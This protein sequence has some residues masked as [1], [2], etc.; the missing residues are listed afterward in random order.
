MTYNMD[1][2]VCMSGHE[3]VCYVGH[4]CPMCDLDTS[5]TEALAENKRLEEDLKAM[6]AQV[7]ELED[8]VKKWHCKET[9]LDTHVGNPCGI[10]GKTWA[11]A[12]C[13]GAKG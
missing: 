8:E 12:G 7:N 4:S 6:T 3:C 11:G 5:Y 2:N 9:M 1:M 10:C 13:D